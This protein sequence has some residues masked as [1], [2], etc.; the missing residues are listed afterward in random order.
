MPLDISE[1]DWMAATVVAVVGLITVLS[2]L[3]SRLD[4]LKELVLANRLVLTLLGELAALT[5]FLVV[6]VSRHGLDFFPPFW[7]W[8]VMTMGS[9]VGL[10]GLSAI[11]ARL[12][13][14]VV[15]F[16]GTV[17]Y[18]AAIASLILGA[19]QFAAEAVIFFNL[20]GAVQVGD[21]GPAA[22]GAT[23]ILE[24]DTEG[25]LQD[26]RTDENGHFRFLLTREEAISAR[27]VRSEINTSGE[28]ARNWEA[29]DWP[30]DQRQYV[31]ESTLI[32]VPEGM[33]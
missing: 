15:L 28:Q 11:S 30:E 26:T 19:T 33:D 23:V 17:L 6:I 22:A 9:I 4:V 14:P 10:L 25:S 32:I 3:T 1:L 18:C 2:P 13:K 20:Q 21:N 16:G 29:I 31:V 5:A 24:G 7:V 12:S 8:F 27:R